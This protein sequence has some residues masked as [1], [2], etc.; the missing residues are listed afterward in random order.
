MSAEMNGWPLTLKVNAAAA[1]LAS[2][3][4]YAKAEAYGGEHLHFEAL[5]VMTRHEYLEHAAAL[6]R[7][8]AP[9][10]APSF[11]TGLRQRVA[12]VIFPKDAR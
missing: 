8:L 11:A 6:L 9:A 3:V 7:S 2:A 5:D 1:R 4:Y 12:G 10:P